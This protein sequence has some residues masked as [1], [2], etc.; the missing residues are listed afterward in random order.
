LVE[1]NAPTI[2][3]FRDGHRS[4][5][6]NYAIVGKTLWMFTELRA[7]KIP[8]SDLDVEATRKV[9][10]DRGVEVPLPE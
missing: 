6:R 2:L 8:M 5:T 3:V 1:E 9:N 10:G 7:R 4:E